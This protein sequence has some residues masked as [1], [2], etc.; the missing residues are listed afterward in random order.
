MKQNKNFTYSVL[1]IGYFRSFVP[2]FDRNCSA[3][4]IFGLAFS[5]DI[6]VQNLKIKPFAYA[7]SF[8]GYFLAFRVFVI[9]FHRL[10]C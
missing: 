4:F 1:S 2:Y 6:T 3:E 5:L 8:M 9:Y 10:S 7:V